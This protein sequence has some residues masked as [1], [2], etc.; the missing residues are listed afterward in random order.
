M[1]KKKIYKFE[2][3]VELEIENMRGFMRAFPA[4]YPIPPEIKEEHE[5]GEIGKNVRLAG[6][7]IE[8]V[9]TELEKIPGVHFQGISGQRVDWFDHDHIVDCRHPDFRPFTPDPSSDDPEMDIAQAAARQMEKE[10]GQ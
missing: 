5:P 6:F 3:T 4:K 10:A 8:A 9:Q 2:F 7:F 1:A